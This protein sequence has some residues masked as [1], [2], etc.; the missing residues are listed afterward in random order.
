MGVIL[1]D[2]FRPKVGV[3]NIKLLPIPEDGWVLIRG[4]GRLLSNL[5]SRE[6]AYSRGCLSGRVLNQSITHLYLY[7]YAIPFP[8]KNF[9][10]TLIPFLLISK[11]FQETALLGASVKCY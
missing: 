7:R 4:R 6:G 3:Q 8:S 10:D 2:P 1:E 9:K 11:L 5:V